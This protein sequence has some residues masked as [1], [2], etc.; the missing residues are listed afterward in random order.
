MIWCGAHDRASLE[1]HGLRLGRAP[2]EG[3]RREQNLRGMGKL[4][5]Q[6]A[7]THVP[8]YPWRADAW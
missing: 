1:Q 2:D 8:G 6:W 4:T 5:G 3:R 7:V